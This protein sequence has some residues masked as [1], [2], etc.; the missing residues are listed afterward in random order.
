MTA[1]FLL[2]QRVLDMAL[3]KTW[4]HQI[5]VKESD[6]L[7]VFPTGGL[8]REHVSSVLHCLLRSLPP[9]SRSTL[10][11]TMHVLGNDIL[12]GN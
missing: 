6:L 2:L 5:V 11:I 8:H 4:S 3:H 12:V 10:K 9:V 7:P 1:N